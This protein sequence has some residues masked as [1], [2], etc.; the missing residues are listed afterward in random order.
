M[1]DSVVEHCPGKHKAL[2]SN[3][4]ATKHSPGLMWG[5]E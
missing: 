5:Q 4:S 1:C 3:P 2:G